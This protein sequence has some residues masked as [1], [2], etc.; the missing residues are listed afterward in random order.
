MEWALLFAAGTLWFW[1][2]LTVATVVIIGCMELE[3]G[4]WATTT[5]VITCALLNVF[6][7]IPILKWAWQDPLTVLMYVGIY[8]T[9]AAIWGV[10]KWELFVRDQ[11]HRYNEAR[12]VF[13]QAN[14]VKGNEMPENLKQK[15]EDEWNDSNVKVDFLRMHN[16]SRGAEDWLHE[17]P[18]WLEKDW[19]RYS[20]Q[21]GQPKHDRWLRCNCANAKIEVNQHKR[22]VLMWMT[23][24]PWSL[25]WH[26]V[27]DP[28]RKICK[29]IFYGMRDYM[30]RR[31]DKIYAGTEQDFPSESETNS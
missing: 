2:L 20:E 4:F 12:A 30:Q 7:D 18:E 31:A 26:L 1:V 14:G 17:I 10:W 13:L 22:K 29:R 23:Y 24:W 15:W 6:G 25:A 19:K 16:R 3:R 21:R 28:V 11:R 5:L 27:N 8:F 9:A